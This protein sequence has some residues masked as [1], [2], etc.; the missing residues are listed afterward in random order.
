[1]AKAGGNGGNNGGNITG[2]NGGNGGRKTGVVIGVD[3]GYSATKLYTEVEGKHRIMIFPS[4]VGRAEFA[5]DFLDLDGESDFIAS[6]DG[7]AETARNFGETAVRLNRG[8]EATTDREEFTDLYN[9]AL[10]LA[11]LARLVAEKNVPEP[12]LVVVGLPVNF[13]SAHRARLIEKLRGEHAVTLYHRDGR[14]KHRVEFNLDQILV[15]PQG[16]GSYLCWALD[17]KGQKIPDRMRPTAVIDGGEKTLDIVAAEGRYLDNYSSSIPSSLDAVY[18][19]MQRE[20]DAAH[21]DY[22]SR[23]QIEAYIR[24]GDPYVSPSGVKVDLAAL[25]ADIL[26][27]HTPEIINRIQAVVKPQRPQHV[28]V[29]GGSGEMLFE[30]LRE[31]FPHAARIEPMVF[32]NAI[33]F[34]KYGLMRQGAHSSAQSGQGAQVVAA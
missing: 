14:V 30:P 17:E 23:S 26:K 25:R 5:E 34:W 21:D 31:V 33:G 9:P 13:F 16:Y 8:G 10:T 3:T 12:D 20:I 1:M 11:G 19:A 28:L 27:R 6:F 4:V 32:S 2:R 29:A 15:L 7:R 22:I 24:S 18:Q